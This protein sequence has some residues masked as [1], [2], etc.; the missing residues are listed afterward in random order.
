[1]N[2]EIKL[3]NIRKNGLRLVSIFALFC[4]ASACGKTKPKENYSFNLAFGTTNGGGWGSWGSWSHCKAETWAI[5]FTTRV[6]ADQGSGDD[7][8]LNAIKL[9]CADLDGQ[10][11][12]T[13]GSNGL[14]GTWSGNHR[15][16][17]PTGEFL[18][19]AV[20]KVEGSQGS[21]GDDTAANSVR[22]KSNTGASYEAANGTPWGTWGSWKGCPSGQ[23]ISGVRIRFEASLGSG[24]DT[25]LNDVQ[26]ECTSYQDVIDRRAWEAAEQARL[27]AEAQ[28][29]ADAE[30]ARVARLGDI[31]RAI[32]D[33]GPTVTLLLRSGAIHKIAFYRL[34]GSIVGAACSIQQ[35]VSFG[36]FS[37]AE[38][39]QQEDLFLASFGTKDWQSQTKYCGSEV[40]IMQ[41]SSCNTQAEIAGEICQSRQAYLD[42]YSDIEARRRKID[43]WRIEAESLGDAS[44]AANALYLRD[45]T[46]LR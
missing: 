15:V 6:E 25:A 12:N 13:V 33:E 35:N 40:T 17:S 31:D 8:G 9:T 37:P 32:R 28:A 39:S 22:F 16:A 10:N 38:I 24:D 14:W 30:A 5:G 34:T 2:V 1:M 44:V 21:G 42:I 18:T 46:Y 36:M 43:N 19:Q 11:Q 26:F 23:A 20:L 29:R 3:N 27:A 4:A 45:Q 41:Y 7:S